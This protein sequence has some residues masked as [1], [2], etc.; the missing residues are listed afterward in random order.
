MTPSTLNWTMIVDNSR[1]RL[2]VVFLAA[3]W[4]Q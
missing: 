4:F 3:A 1:V 2:G